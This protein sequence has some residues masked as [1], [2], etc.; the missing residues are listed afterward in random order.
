MKNHIAGPC[1][2]KKITLFPPPAIGRNRP[3]DADYPSKHARS[4]YHSRAQ[5]ERILLRCEYCRR[6]FRISPMPSARR[7]LY[8]RFKGGT[9]MNK[10]VFA[11]TVVAAAMFS[12]INWG[13]ALLAATSGALAISVTVAEKCRVDFSEGSADFF[14]VCS[15]AAGVANERSQNVL[16]SAIAIDPAAD[17]YFLDRDPDNPTRG[18]AAAPGSAAAAGV[19]MAAGNARRGPKVVVIN[20]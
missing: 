4:L 12:Q 9:K 18:A 13:S 7:R 11:V 15:A 20:Y 5:R 16:G 17:P 1:L 14:Q 6:D 2:R 3:H 8:S 19:A 10:K